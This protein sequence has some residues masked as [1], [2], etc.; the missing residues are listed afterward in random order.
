MTRRS[1]VLAWCLS[2]GPGRRR[3]FSHSSDAGVV[4]RS[5]PAQPPRAFVDN[6]CAQAKHRW[7]LAGRS[8]WRVHR[9]SN[10]I[11]MVISWFPYALLERNNGLHK[12]LADGAKTFVA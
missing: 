10:A 7:D 4:W 8:V 1:V 9:H 6:E 5:F 12:V 3:A 2:I 11:H